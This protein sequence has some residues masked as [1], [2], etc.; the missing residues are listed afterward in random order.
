MG[1]TFF[2]RENLQHSIAQIFLVFGVGFIARP[3]GGYFLGKLGDKFGGYFAVKVA[4]YGMSI[5]SFLIAF[6]PGYTVSGYWA[7]LLLVLLRFIQGL[8]AGGQFSGLM[9]IVT[10]TTRKKRAFLASIAYSVST[11]GFLLAVI[12]AYCLHHLVPTALSHYE[13]RLAFVISGVWGLIYHLVNKKQSMAV[14]I[15]KEDNE[16]FTLSHI[17][18]RQYRAVIGIVL[19]TFFLASLYY[20]SFSYTYTYFTEVMHIP[21]N[22]SYYISIAML[23]IGVILYPIFG[24]IADKYNKQIVSVIGAVAI[25]PLA[26]LFVRVTN[27]FLILFISIGLVVCTAA[28]CSGIVSITAEVFFKRWRMTG[29]AVTYNVGAAIAGFFPYLSQSVVTLYGRTALDY[30]LFGAVIIGLTGHV[31]VRFSKGHRYIT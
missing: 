17:L 27:T 23:I 5:A 18:T 28:V 4:V 25:F 16:G 15:N 26:Y 30:L 31:F 21:R 8:S 12:I 2:P 14:T 29:S 24:M 1:K 10:E 7:I 3:F 19:L 11:L 20:F 13:W 6:L 9:S 22:N